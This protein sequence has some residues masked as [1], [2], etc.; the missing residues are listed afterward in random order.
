ML[1][2]IGKIF[3]LDGS[4]SGPV[5]SVEALRDISIEF[6]TGEIHALLGENGAGKSTLMHILSGLHAPSQGDLEVAGIRRSF[7]S[8]AQAL[9]EGIAMV[10]QHPLTARDLTVLENCKPGSA[11]PGLNGGSLRAAVLR[12]C[13]QWDIPLDPDTPVSRL[14]ALG[15]LQTALLAA[16]IHTPRFLLLDE[17]TG[18]LPPDERDG[19]L[20]SL[21]RSADNGT[22]IIL[23]THNIGEACRWADRISVLQKGTLAWSGTP[24]DQSAL[25][26]RMFGPEA[27]R[28]I[29]PPCPVHSSPGAS[30]RLET[31]SVAR[32]NTSP[33]YD[34]NLTVQP[35][36]ITGIFGL[37][38]SGLDT[39]ESVFAGQIKPDTGRLFLQKDGTSCSVK[40]AALRSHSVA[41]IPSD[42]VFRGSHPDLTLLEMMSPYRIKGFIPDLKTRRAEVRA[43]LQREGITGDENRT[44]RSL[45]GGQ[46][47][48][49]ILERELSEDPAVLILAEPAWG[50]DMISAN[51]LFERLRC[52]ADR[53]TAVLV[54]TGDFDTMNRIQLFDDS[55]ILRAGHLE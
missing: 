17:P 24:P 48:R 52:A 6:R 18:F 4:G 40:P 47:Q 1:R 5:E 39:L 43:V 21:R 49:L 32:Y 16:L 9:S 25:E 38:G 34:I 46:L 31:V 8:P 45:S 15:R 35:G 37:A 50:L 28:R 23:I 54:L 20:A 51:I 19:L 22:G 11:R 41:L 3:S 26:E 44:V 53:G 27:L 30:L 10:H 29:A 33:L 2:G 14:D 36:R 12:L 55:R 42:R 7:T 13:R